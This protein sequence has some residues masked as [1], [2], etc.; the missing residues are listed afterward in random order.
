[1]AIATSEFD[2]SGFNSRNVKYLFNRTS[3][4]LLCM[5]IIIHQLIIEM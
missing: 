2:E 3:I 4:T 1:M 5:L